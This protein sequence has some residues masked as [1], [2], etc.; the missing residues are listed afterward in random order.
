MRL[1]GLP[2]VIDGLAIVLRSDKNVGGRNTIKNCAKLNKS[3]SKYS[4]N[5]PAPVTELVQSVLPVF[6]QVS[7]TNSLQCLQTLFRYLPTFFQLVKT[8]C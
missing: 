4:S 6:L 7:L 2:G 1:V 5:V 8:C 3:S